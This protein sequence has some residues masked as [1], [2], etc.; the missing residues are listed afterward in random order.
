MEIDDE[1]CSLR[2]FRRPTFVMQLACGKL[3]QFNLDSDEKVK[4]SLPLNYNI[5]PNLSKNASRTFSYT[6]SAKTSSR[7]SVAVHLSSCYSEQSV[8]FL[9]LSDFL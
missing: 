2:R 3:T 9:I 4:S 5:L 8:S 7:Y 1:S 6:C